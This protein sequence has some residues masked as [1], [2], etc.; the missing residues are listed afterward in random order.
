MKF[1]KIQSKSFIMN[2]YLFLL[3][4]PF[5]IPIHF[6]FADSLNDIDSLINDGRL[7]ILEREYEKAIEYFDK[8]LEIEPDNQI[9]L[10]NIA[11]ALIN[12]DK[13]NEAIMYVDKVLQIDP[14]NLI[15]LNNKGIAYLRMNNTVTA[16]KYFSQALDIDPSYKSARD[17]LFKIKGLFQYEKVDGS[18]EMILRDSEGKLV[19]FGKTNELEIMKHTIVDLELLSWDV[20]DVFTK[21]DQKYEIIQSKHVREI[22]GATSYGNYGI[23]VTNSPGIWLVFAHYYQVPV[24][25]GDE[26]TFIFRIV[27]AI[28]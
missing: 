9:A 4:F 8:V 14:E 3:F 11:T 19:A 12:L 27:R 1:K 13:N 5:F 17:N 25:V 2:S 7:S 21:N 28:V 23:Q 26:L 20:V 16:E 18:F 24:E 15:A 6:V 22:N 10:N